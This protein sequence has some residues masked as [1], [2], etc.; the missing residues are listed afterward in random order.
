MVSGE[1]PSLPFHV[2][3]VPATAPVSALRHAQ[4]L[5]LEYGHFL[6]GQLS[7]AQ[8]CFGSLQ[9]EAA[10]L[11]FFYLEQGGGCLMA[12]AKG[13]PA[14]FIAW[15]TLPLTIAPAAWELKRLWVRPAA[16]GLGLGRALLKAALDRAV[17]AGQQSVFLDTAP[18][19]MA[20]AVRLYFELG[21]KPCAPYRDHPVEG[22]AY[23]V[24]HL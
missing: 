4:E 14:G 20:T 9:K 2:E 10:R 19:A 24:K 21:F 15:R 23:F 22:L 18:D 13:E 17:A 11:P 1:A 8:F 16:R 7:A 5:L 12:Y 3:E 6:A